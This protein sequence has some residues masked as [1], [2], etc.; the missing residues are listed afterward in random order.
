M[1]QITGAISY[2]YQILRYRHDVATGEFA[3]IGLVFYEPVGKTLLVETVKDYHRLSMFFGSVPG[4]DLLR[5]LGNIKTDLKKTA[6]RSQQDSN[7]TDVK[8]ITDMTASVLPDDDNALFFSEVFTGWHFD[9]ESAFQD[10]HER[11]LL[12]YTEKAVNE[13][14]V[15]E[16][17][18]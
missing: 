6:A 17:I 1:E 12:S 18:G 2:Q 3:D 7:H 4:A 8:S 9:A 11:L 13:K 10:L 5:L 16:V 14:G 15:P